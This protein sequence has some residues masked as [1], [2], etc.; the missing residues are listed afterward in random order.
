MLINSFR[1]YRWN[2]AWFLLGSG[3]SRYFEGKGIIMPEE[4]LK[5]IGSILIILAIGTGFWAW[6]DDH[7][8]RSNSTKQDKIR[9]G[10]VSKVDTLINE[11]RQDRDE[12]KKR[13]NR[14]DW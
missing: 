9:E 2:I 3:I 12:R 10:L 6:L 13:E 1:K 8:A 14:D 5:H 7:H 4:L 11:I